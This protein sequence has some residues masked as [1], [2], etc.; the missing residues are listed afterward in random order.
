[1]KERTRWIDALKGIAILGVVMVH[2]GKQE[3]PQQYE[4]LVASGKYGVQMFFIISAYLLFV[5]LENLNNKSIF[6]WYK[7]KTKRIILLYYVMLVVCILSEG[8]KYWLGSVEKITHGNIIAHILGLHAL[9]PYYMNS[10]IGV[11][12]YIG[13]YFL[14]I[15]ISPILF[16]IINTLESSIVLFVASLVI[17][18]FMR[19]IPSPLV[20]NDKYLWDNYLNSYGI[21][22]QVPVIALGIMLYFLV[23]KEKI[24]QS[25]KRKKILSYSILVGMLFFMCSLMKG[26]N[27][28]NIQPHILYALVFMGI[29]FSQIIYESPLLNNTFLSFLGRKSYGIYLIHFYLIQSDVH[30]WIDYLRVKNVYIKWIL[31]YVLILGTSLVLAE[32]IEYCCTKIG[33]CRR[34]YCKKE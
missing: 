17:N 4:I 34:L 14:L 25:Y 22:A 32:G 26:V 12:W 21:M 6:Q 2:F 16:R 10:I 1:M 23:N 5:S 19:Q 20:Q 31:G 7:K 27:V 3:L 15:L 11:E 9:N 30:S 18:V 29:I 24:F 28:S 13:N 8:Q 33:K